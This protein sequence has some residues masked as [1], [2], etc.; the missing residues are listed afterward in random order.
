MRSSSVALPRSIALTRPLSMLVTIA[1]ADVPLARPHDDLE[2]GAGGH[3]GQA[4]AHDPGADDA[5]LA[6]SSSG[7][8]SCPSSRPPHSWIGAGYLPAGN[9]GQDPERS[10]AVASRRR[11]ARHA[12]VL[13]RDRPAEGRRAAEP[14]GRRVAAGEHRRALLAPRHGR[15]PVRPVRR[16]TRR[17]RR[18]DHHGAHPRHRRD[19]RRRH[20]RLRRGRGRGQQGRPRGGRR[21][22]AV[23]PAPAGGR[24]PGCA[25]CGSPTSVATRPRPGWSWPS[26]VSPRCC[27]T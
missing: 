3:L 23:R 22:P 19:R 26:T 2:P 24:A 13:P 16:R 9:N 8:W 1:S 6:R 17:P 21:R 10:S 14:P 4:G 27:S 20:V 7:W 25:R 11:S 12:G 5:D 18:G 15:R